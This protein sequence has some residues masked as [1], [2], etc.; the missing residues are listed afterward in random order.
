MN[1]HLPSTTTLALSR[2]SAA[3]ATKREPKQRR[4][5]WE[6]K[7]R[8]TLF[9]ARSARSGRPCSKR[10][11]RSWY[12][13]LGKPRTDAHFAAGPLPIAE[14]SESEVFHPRALQRL[15]PPQEKDVAWEQYDPSMT[16]ISDIENTSII[17]YR[18]LSNSETM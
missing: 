1:T 7:T 16:H 12:S 10:L 9:F 17:P 18:I 3:L 8:N 5:F 4:C 15:C 14:T 11:K 2:S 13:S 6:E